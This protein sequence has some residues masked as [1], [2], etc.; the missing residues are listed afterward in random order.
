MLVNES[1]PRRVDESVMSTSDQPS[2]ERIVVL[3]RIG[4]RAAYRLLGDREDAKDIAQEAVARAIVRWP[5]VSGYADQ[6]VVTVAVNLAI[7]MLRRRRPTAAGHTESTTDA[8]AT[9]RLDLARSLRKLPR[10]QREVV[11]LRYLADL[12]QREVAQRLGCSEGS[13]KQH[14]SRGLGALRADLGP[15]WLARGGSE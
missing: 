11:V 7:G 6:W 9:E 15:A 4:Y 2:D 3:G 10:R 8:L 14:A 12:T 1:H 5:K 13:V